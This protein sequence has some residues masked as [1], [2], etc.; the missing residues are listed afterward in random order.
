MM[1]NAGFISSTVVWERGHA[2]TPCRKLASTDASENLGFRVRG[3][4]MS[5]LNI[6]WILVVRAATLF[7]I[8]R[9]H[10]SANPLKQAGAASPVP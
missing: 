3:L 4:G 8:H 10:M 7:V 9:V 5:P 6:I 2:G 1:G